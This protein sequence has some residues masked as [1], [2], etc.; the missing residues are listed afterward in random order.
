M[1]VAISKVP[2]V[3]SVDV[4]LERAMTDIRLT[5][6]NAVTIAQLRQIIKSNGFNAREATVTALGVLSTE[7]G[8]PTV[9]VDGTAMTWVLTRDAARPDAFEEARRLASSKPAVEVKGTLAAPSTDIDTPRLT[10][11]SIAAR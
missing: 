10:L 9:S 3:E 7:R 11:H 8:E 4:S 1:R 5:T 2:G 6:G